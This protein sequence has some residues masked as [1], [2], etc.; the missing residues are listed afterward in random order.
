[1]E[2]FKKLVGSY[3]Q[4]EKVGILGEA[5]IRQMIYLHLLVKSITA[6]LL[7]LLLEEVFG[8]K[9]VDLIVDMYQHT[10]RTPIWHFQLG[11]KG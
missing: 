7:Q 3:L 5:E 4:V 8:W 2:L 6:V 11:A 10:V 9:W 1:M